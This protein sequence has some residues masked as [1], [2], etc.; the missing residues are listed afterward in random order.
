MEIYEK[1]RSVPET[2]QK[3][4]TGGRLNGKTDINPM[5]RIKK[6]TE[7]FGPCGYGWKYQIKNMRLE[8]GAD[9]EIAAFVEID[10]FFKT[11]DGWSEAIPGTGGSMFVVKE[12]NGLYTNDECFKMALTDALSVAC[13]ALGFGADIYWGKDR[14]KYDN[15]VNEQNHDVITKESASI[16]LQT[17]IRKYGDKEKAKPHLNALLNKYKA[18][19]ITDITELQAKEILSEIQEAS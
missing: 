4:I 13:K 17:L 7:L 6:L 5:W 9:G 3:K 2:A 19:S 18:K 16:I 1:A 12:K 15:R 10:L 8:T 11:S 14:T